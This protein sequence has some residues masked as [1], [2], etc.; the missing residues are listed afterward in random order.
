MTSVLTVLRRPQF[1]LINIGIRALPLRTKELDVF[2][3]GSLTSIR[4]FFV[5]WGS[6]NICSIIFEIE[7][8]H[9]YKV[10]V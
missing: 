3:L 10:A 2:D 8:M 7:M 4:L 6:K 1:F 5:F 9:S